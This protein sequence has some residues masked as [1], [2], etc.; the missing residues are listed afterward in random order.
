MPLVVVAPS[1]VRVPLLAPASVIVK[2]EFKL[3]LPAQSTVPD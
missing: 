3:E 2:S 1:T